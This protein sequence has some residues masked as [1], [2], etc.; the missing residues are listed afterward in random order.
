MARRAAVVLDLF[1]YDLAVHQLDGNN[2]VTHGRSYMKDKSKA[3]DQ[4]VFGLI[5]L[6]F[7]TSDQPYRSRSRLGRRPSWPPPIATSCPR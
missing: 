4:D 2:G 5:K 7:A 3:G 6:L 1:L